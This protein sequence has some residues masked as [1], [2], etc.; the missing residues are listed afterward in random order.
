MKAII[1]VK[2]GSAD[3]LQLQK[4]EKPVPGAD[5]VLV[6]IYATTVTAGDVVLRKLVWPLRILFRLFLGIGK[7]NI[8][9][10][11][12]A[13]EIEAVGKDV[14]RFKAGD[15]VFATTGPGGGAYAE[16]KCLPEDGMLAL[17]PANVSY[18]E[19][20]AVPIGGN[21]ALYILKQANI[22]PGQKVLVYGASGSVGTYA[23]QLTKHFGAQVT[24]VCST[25]NV[26]MVAGLGADKVIDYTQQDFIQGGEVYDVIFDAVGKTSA[27]ACKSIL[28]ADG[29]F[30]TVQ[31]STKEEPENLVLLKELLETGA[32]KAVIDKRYALEEIPEAHRY[33]ET[34]RKKGNVVIIVQ[35]E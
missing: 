32:L 28:K 2:Y 9:G 14:T 20:A 5:E 8:F 17:K 12:F 6:K 30:L 27:S 31:S 33:V 3:G 16:Y 22:Q 7:S 35:A 4:V 21:T 11:E 26:D 13:G 23:V 15:Q 34:G 1:C 24:G 19:A 18:A 29:H 10:H 25:A